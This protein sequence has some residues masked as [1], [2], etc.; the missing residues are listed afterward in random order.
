VFA[1]VFEMMSAVL[2]GGFDPGKG[3]RGEHGR[4]IFFVERNFA[5]T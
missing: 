4:K 5:P 1:G 3:L 2:H